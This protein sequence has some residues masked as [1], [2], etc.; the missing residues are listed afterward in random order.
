MYYD[1][2]TATICQ[3]CGEPH[4]RPVHYFSVSSHPVEVARVPATALVQGMEYSWSTSIYTMLR[5]A[6][7]PKRLAF[8]TKSSRYYSTASGSNSGNPPSFFHNEANLPKKIEPVPE[9]TVLA[10]KEPVSLPPKTHFED[11]SGVDS[12]K[13]ALSAQQAVMPPKP[14]FSDPANA[15]LPP[16]TPPPGPSA[17][18][19][20]YFR[21]YKDFCKGMAYLGVGMGVIFF[22]FDQHERL[23]VS[24][25]QMQLMKKKQKELVLQMQTY[26]NKLNKVAVENAKKNVL[27][28]GKMQMHVA[29]LREQLLELGAD[30][31][32]IAMAIDKFE[33]DVK[34]DVA[35]NTVELW[36]PGES[37]LKSLIPDPHEYSK[38]K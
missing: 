31:V 25:R 8:G 30:P 1:S 35:S 27:V 3:S 12:A 22:M 20:N 7:A 29:L 23:D 4:R 15:S 6:V 28:Q 17:D 37:K 13:T 19:S 16:P 2:L 34:V 36:V 11:N 9:N 32:S 5:I 26:K 38:K 14:L 21:S 10:K 24:E 33:Q 18:T